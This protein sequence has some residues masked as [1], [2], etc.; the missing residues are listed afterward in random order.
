[1][2]I[3]SQR[4]DA[5]SR[6]EPASPDEV[7]S[8]N[9][10][11]SAIKSEGLSVYCERLVDTDRLTRLNLAAILNHVKAVRRTQLCCGG[12]TLKVTFRERR[13]RWNR[14]L[15]RTGRTESL[16]TSRISRSILPSLPSQTETT[17]ERTVGAILPDPKATCKF[18][19]L[20]STGRTYLIACYEF[21]LDFCLETGEFM[22]LDGQDPLRSLILVSHGGRGSI[23]LACG[24]SSLKMEAS[25]PRT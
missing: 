10:L 9:G 15:S 21:A 11:P 20:K 2:E 1:M 3:H 23:V 14:A 22:G 25:A 16:A 12:K 18:G 6:Q 5:I 24:I 19:H 17:R 4:C 13:E 7:L 8:Q